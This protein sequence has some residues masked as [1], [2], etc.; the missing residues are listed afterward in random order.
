MFLSEQGT[1][2]HHK[3]DIFFKFYIFASLQH[4]LL[5]FLCFIEGF[6][7]KEAEYKGIV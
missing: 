3:P 6:I 4:W 5:L 7:A 2:I 1:A